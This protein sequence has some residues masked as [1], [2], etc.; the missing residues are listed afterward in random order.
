MTINDHI[1]KKIV[2][3]VIKSEDYR[4]EVVNLLNGEFLQFAVDFFKEIALAKLSDEDISMDWYKKK[5]LSKNLPS[6]DIAN[7]SG[8]NLKTIKNMYGSAARNIVLD[9]SEEHFETFYETVNTLITDQPDI[10]LTLTIKFKAISVELNVTE[11]LIVINAL[12]VK[13]ASLRGGIW[14][15][16]GKKAEKVLML[17]LCKLYKVSEDNYNAEHFVKDKTLDFDREIDFYLKKNEREYKCEVKLM[18]GGNPESADA[19]IARNSDV[20]VADTLSKQNKNQCEALGIQW[21]AC[22]DKE[23]YKN[24]AKALKKFQIPYE[25]YNG[26]LD[27]DL[28]DILNEIF[29]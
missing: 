19:I 21:V 11:S 23:G 25:D 10:D 6:V 2:E 17:A 22:R 13:R 14:S 4:I 12:A 1:T 15:T 9:A 8:L 29:S 18:G 28:P 24:F 27:E 3:H 20:F 26:N 16:A 5:F 7:N